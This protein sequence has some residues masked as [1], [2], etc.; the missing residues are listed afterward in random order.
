MNQGYKDIYTVWSGDVF[1]MCCVCVDIDIYLIYL[2][3]PIYGT[4]T[5]TSAQKVRP[6]SERSVREI[7]CVILQ[8]KMRRSFHVNYE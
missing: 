8:R 4:H 1:F 3:I 2:Y 5:R 7:G 6:L